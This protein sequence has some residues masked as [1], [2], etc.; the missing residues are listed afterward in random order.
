LTDNKLFGTNGIRFIPGKEYG[1]DFIVN[2]GLSIGTFFDKP[3]IIVG[4]D[5]RNSS[6]SISRAISAGLMESGKNVI[7]AGMVP[8][9]ALQLI[10]K[11]SY[12]GGVMITASHNPS[13]YN[14]IK[15][16]SSNGIEVSRSEEKIIEN[17][18]FQQKYNR[19]NWENVGKISSD[20]SSIN[21]Y[22]H[23]VIQNVDSSSI[24]NRKLKIVIDS[25]NGTQ[26]L[27]A[28]L[29]SESL[30][31]EV[32][33][34]NNHIDGTFSGRGGEPTPDTLKFLSQSVVE[35]NADIGVGFDGDGD[36]SIFCDEKGIVFWGDKSGTLVSEHLINK[37]IKSPIVTTIATSLIIEKVASKYNVNV[38][39]TKVGSVDVSHKMLELDSK[40]GFE[41]NG[42]CLYSPHVAVRDGGM[43][44]ALMLELL[45]F[46][47]TTLS[48]NLSTLPNF[49]QSKTKFSCPIDSR[50]SI[51]HDIAS[52]I[53]EEIDQTDGLKIHW[54]E[55]SWSLIRPSGTEPIIRLFSESDSQ[56]HLDAIMTKCSTLVNDLIKNLNS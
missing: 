20:T 56:S 28:P 6:P 29:I 35:N 33:T 48:E 12:D 13:E 22:I 3:D 30:G 37:G 53:S 19:Q 46:S 26:A 49:Y 23:S 24:K 42:G 47:D 15:V 21:N 8:T 52:S 14:G 27:A 55:N 36:R 9:P 18:Y 4:F 34:V 17:I 1:L 16:I 41:E 39:R 50:E 54:S 44:T 11:N 2:M 31:C 32:I 5:G 10:T 43:G 7:S 40:F 25:G 38:H 45:S 51:I